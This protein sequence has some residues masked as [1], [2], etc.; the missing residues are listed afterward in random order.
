MT[1]TPSMALCS[2]WATVELVGS[3]EKNHMNSVR[4]ALKGWSRCQK[5]GDSRSV[6]SSEDSEFEMQDP[7]RGFGFQS[8]WVRFHL[9]MSHD[10]SPVPPFDTRKKK[11]THT[12]TPHLWNLRN[13]R[14]A[15]RVKSSTRLALLSS[16]KCLCCGSCV[17]M[18]MPGGSGA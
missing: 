16:C 1:L 5:A 4:T 11:K 3:G 17:T 18:C 7:S 14:R 9:R 12:H 15:I 8:V 10:E 2:L 6:N 13:L